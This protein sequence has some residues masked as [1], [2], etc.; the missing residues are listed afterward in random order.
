MASWNPA[1]ELRRKGHKPVRI[2]YQ[3]PLIMEKLAD[4][5]LNEE[6]KKNG[7]FLRVFYRLSFYR[8]VLRY[9]QSKEEIEEKRTEREAAKEISVWRAA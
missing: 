1:R 5:K 8:G 3:G 4:E 7:D 6:A 2:G 9:W